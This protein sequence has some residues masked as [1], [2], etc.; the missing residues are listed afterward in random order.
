MTAKVAG[1]VSVTITENT[2]YPFSDTITFTL[3]LASPTAF[4]F[5]VRIPGWCSAPALTVNG[6]AVS[7]RRRAS[8]RHR[9][10][11]LVERRHRHAAAADASR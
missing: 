3:A 10:P 4:P 7:G 11:H 1:G 5:T 2:D 8:V 6:S 9:Q